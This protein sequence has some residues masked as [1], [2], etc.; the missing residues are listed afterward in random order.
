MVRIQ[1]DIT[2]PSESIM[3]NETFVQ[4][5]TNSAQPTKER[6]IFVLGSKGVGKT[7]IINNFLDRSETIKP[8]LA[9]EYSFGRRSGGPGQGLQK[10]VCNVWELGSLSNSSSLMNVPI[11]SHGFENFA[12]IIVLNLLYPDRLWGDLEAALNGLKQ[13]ITTYANKE[14]YEKWQKNAVKRVGTN[15]TD[16][17]TLDLFP[18]PVVIIGGYYDKFQDFDPVIKRHVGRCLRSIAHVIGAALIYY[19]SQHSALSKTVR[20][21]FNHFGFGSP[22]KPFR[23]TV[24]D[25]NEPLI[26][27]FGQDSW[28]SIGVGPTNSE[29]I[30]VT[31]DEQ[32]PQVNS[33]DSNTYLPVSNPA[34]EG[35]FRESVIDEIRA[36]KDEELLRWVKDNE[37]QNKFQAIATTN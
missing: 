17:P 19:S 9:L 28:Q 12:S 36:Q 20:D 32:I 29:R 1:F 13:T 7:S 23:S 6:T 10:Q 22:T 3:D 5:R 30:K 8:T 16:L 21:T 4:D 18:F 37:F 35:D 27:W 24:I 31:Y 25:Y 33:T 11:K 14:A 15:H 26:I 34:K 2:I